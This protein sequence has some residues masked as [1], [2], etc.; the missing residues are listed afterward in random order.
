MLCST[1]LS[2]SLP[3]IMLAS[4]LN[5]SAEK[6]L[7]NN[8]GREKGRYQSCVTQVSCPSLQQECLGEVTKRLK[9]HFSCDVI[10]LTLILGIFLRKTCDSVSCTYYL[11][12]VR[13]IFMSQEV[14]VASRCFAPID[15]L[16]QE[17]CQFLVSSRDQVWFA[18]QAL[19]HVLLYQLNNRLP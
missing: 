6:P 1:S 18:V 17:L 8:I 5:N 15:I 19:V 12:L 16:I 10:S 7:Q 4:N 13:Q 2:L 11:L 9:I 14:D 3:M